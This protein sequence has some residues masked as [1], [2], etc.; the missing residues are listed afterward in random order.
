MTTHLIR[1]G[2]WFES[3][4]ALLQ[5]QKSVGRIH[6]T[7]YRFCCNSFTHRSLLVLSFGAAIVAV[8]VEIIIDAAAVAVAV[9]VAAAVAV[10][11]VD[12]WFAL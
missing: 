7:L 9:A 4:N 12:A 2:N 3:Q 1:K 11:V 6:L 8:N 10:A 5:T